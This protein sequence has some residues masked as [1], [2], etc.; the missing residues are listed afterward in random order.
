MRLRHSEIAEQPNHQTSQL[1]KF[2]RASE[3]HIL[4]DRDFFALVDSLHPKNNYR[5]SRSH[6]RSLANP[7]SCHDDVVR[8]S[9]QAYQN[10]VGTLLLSALDRF[11]L[12]AS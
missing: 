10:Q 4:I 12:M 11:T 2:V 6:L 1:I 7:L 8:G 9:G 3:M 5:Y